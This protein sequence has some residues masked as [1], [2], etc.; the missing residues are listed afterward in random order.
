MPVGWNDPPWYCSACCTTAPIHTVVPGL[1]G[2]VPYCEYPWRTDCAA[3]RSPTV[4]RTQSTHRHT[5][6]QRRCPL[7][8][9]LTGASE[10]PVRARAGGRAPPGTERD[11]FECVWAHR[12]GSAPTVRRGHSMVLAEWYR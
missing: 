2:R 1:C 10:S 3:V 4:V 8:A 12:A 6:E 5:P 11:P 7:S 9:G